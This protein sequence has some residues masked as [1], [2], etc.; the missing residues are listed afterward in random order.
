MMP[1]AND[2]LLLVGDA[3][4]FADLQRILLRHGGAVSALVDLE[5]LGRGPVEYPYPWSWQATGFGLAALG[6]SV[7][8]PRVGPC[9]LDLEVDVLARTPAPAGVLVACLRLARWEWS[10]FRKVRWKLYAARPPVR[11]LE[12]VGRRC[13]ETASTR[14]ATS[15][16]ARS[17]WA[18]LLNA[19]A[20]EPVWLARCAAGLLRAWTQV[21]SGASSF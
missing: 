14:R 3:A 13:F 8:W 7:R 19:G 18:K 1:W 6:G 2:A 12:R 17:A 10:Y 16:R 15:P 21:P 20:P 9:D 4:A 11:R 5:S